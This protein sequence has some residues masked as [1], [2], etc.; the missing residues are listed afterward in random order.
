MI[1]VTCFGGSS[2]EEVEAYIKRTKKFF[3]VDWNIIKIKKCPDQ[4]TSTLLDEEKKFLSMEN[5]FSIL[6]VKGEALNDSEFFKWVT[7]ADQ[8]LVIGP[9]IGFHPDFYKKAKRKVSLSPL[10]FTHGLA[11]LML[12]ESIYRV[13]CR[14][15]NHP[16]CK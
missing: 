9:A 10:T 16:F 8:H 5:N 2:F 6:D 1:R 13:A 12:A 4:R 15:T 3:R 11:Q 14:M 7:S